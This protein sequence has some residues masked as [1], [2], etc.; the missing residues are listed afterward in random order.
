MKSFK[1]YNIY[2]QRKLRVAEL[3]DLEHKVDC[4][5]LTM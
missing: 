4:E 1:L 2:P 3:V 5:V